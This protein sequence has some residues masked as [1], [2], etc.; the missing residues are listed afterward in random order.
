MKRLV[1]RLA[2]AVGM[3]VPLML[4]QQAQAADR[5]QI[6]RGEYLAR[7]ADCMACHT[8]LCRDKGKLGHLLCNI[9]I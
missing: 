2:M 1:S 5:Q 6:E 3:A 9:L 8:G 4:A 7:A